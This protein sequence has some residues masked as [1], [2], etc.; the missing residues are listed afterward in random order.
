MH[1]KQF[2]GLNRKRSG[3]SFKFHYENLGGKSL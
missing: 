2:A 3:K 1:G